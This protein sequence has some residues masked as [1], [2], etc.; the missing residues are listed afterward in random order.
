MVKK[1]KYWM[2]I[3]FDNW[4]IGSGCCG[5]NFFDEINN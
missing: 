2:I 3:I 5:I 1:S 4:K